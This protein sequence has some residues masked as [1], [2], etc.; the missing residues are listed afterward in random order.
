MLTLL[1]IDITT[2]ILTNQKPVHRNK[3]EKYIKML[4]NHSLWMMKIWVSFSSTFLQLQRFYKWTH[5]VFIME[6]HVI[7]VNYQNT[8]IKTIQG[9]QDKIFNHNP[10]TT[11]LFVNYFPDFFPSLTLCILIANALTIRQVY[12]QML[13]GVTV[14]YWEHGWLPSTLLNFPKFAMSMYYI[15]NGKIHT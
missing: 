14:R 8:M 9:N 10:T 1:Q 15:F 4:I 6:I 13:T 7:K 11:P 2:T 5:S 12:R 3:M